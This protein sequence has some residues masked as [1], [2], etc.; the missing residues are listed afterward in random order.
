M[1]EANCSTLWILIAFAL[2]ALKCQSNKYAIAFTALQL[3]FTI[4]LGNCPGKGYYLEG[5][6]MLALETSNISEQPHG[7][8][9]CSYAAER[10]EEP[11]WANLCLWQ[12]LQLQRGWRQPRTQRAHLNWWMLWSWE[13]SHQRRA[14]FSE[15]R[16][17]KP[18]LNEFFYEPEF[19]YATLSE[20]MRTGANNTK[21][22]NTPT[23][24][25]YQSTNPVISR[26]CRNHGAD[27]KAPF[28]RNSPSKT[29]SYSLTTPFVLQRA[30]FL[31]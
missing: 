12:Q 5:T 11:E 7:P 20:F 13:N 14:W 4:L 16:R 21:M 19:H 18:T 22:Q 31:L 17:K 27:G 26:T 28:P 8:I 2:Q 6:I 10:Q 30:Q 29:I 15:W 9:I 25:L 3:P 1:K 23:L 24:Q